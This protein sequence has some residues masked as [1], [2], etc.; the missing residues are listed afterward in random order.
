MTTLDVGALTV[1]TRTADGALAD[2]GPQW[3]DLAARCRAATPFQS[4][5]WLSSWWRA[6]G[7]P[8]RLRL[9]LVRA[10]ARLIAAAPLVAVHRHGCPVLTP[11]GG[12]FADFTDVLVDDGVPEAAHA[13]VR[14]LVTVPGWQVVDFPET[15]P[16][17]VAA[18]ALRAAWTGRSWEA[19]ASLC[20][21]LPGMPFD[22]LVAG[23][24]QHSRK[25]VKRRLNQL[26]K[27][28]P[29]VRAVDAELAGGAPG[30]AEAAVADLL[31][32]HAAQWA[33]RGGNRD[34]LTPQFRAHLAG[35]VPGMIR[36]GQAVLWEY[37]FGG[38]LMAS[39]LVL[40]GGD[41]VG[42]YLFGADPGLR[43]LVDVTVMLLADTVPL[44]HRLG[45]PTMSMLRGAEEHKRR[46]RP[47]ESVNRRILLGRPRSVR[48][49]V[50]AGGVLGY[51]RAVGVAKERAPWLRTVRDWVRR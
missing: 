31:R 51:R 40:V 5:A 46:W 10:G 43:D 16:G 6:Y 47:N 39:S 33:G 49:P 2:L 32:L 22:E 42:G 23:L 18:T 37:R 19:D 7:V 50:Y 48:A 15:R 35:A 26:R 12:T 27:A 25:T 1:E 38:R 20:L 28:A 4:H 30:G 17:S 11:L 21:E 34:H 36:D 3:N 45:R 9:V 29:E 13:L 44:A 8:G 24:P 14:A 41:H